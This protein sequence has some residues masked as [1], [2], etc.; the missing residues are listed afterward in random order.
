MNIDVELE[1]HD[2]MAQDEFDRRRRQH[3]LRHWHPLD[4]DRLEDDFEEPPEQEISISGVELLE[5]DGQQLLK[6]V[7]N[8]E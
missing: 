7:D 6:K 2:L 8:A 5:K 1:A 4:P 3:Q